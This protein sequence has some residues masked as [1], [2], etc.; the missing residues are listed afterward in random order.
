MTFMRWCGKLRAG[1]ERSSTNRQIDMLDAY[2]FSTTFAAAF[3]STLSA[4]A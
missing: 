1:H 3:A 4:W 2:S